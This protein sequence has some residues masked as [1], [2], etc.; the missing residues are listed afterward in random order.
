MV[1]PKIKITVRTF[2]Q[3]EDQL[4]ML[5]YQHVYIHSKQY[6]WEVC[7]EACLT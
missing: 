7:Y 4:E 6:A 2:L 3:V 1:F 5:S